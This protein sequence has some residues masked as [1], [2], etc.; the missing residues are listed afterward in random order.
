MAKALRWVRGGASQLY[1]PASNRDFVFGRIFFEAKAAGQ[2]GFTQH[3]GSLLP[4]G[5]DLRPRPCPAKTTHARF[6]LPF[7][8]AVVE[9][10]SAV[11]GLSG[12]QRAT[13]SMGNE[14]RFAAR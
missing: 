5:A 7:L 6:T 11:A 13:W 8:F 9:L 1:S 12:S 2:D 4:V 10:L 14:S 3:V